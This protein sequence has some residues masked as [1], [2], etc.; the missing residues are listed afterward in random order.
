MD[1][2]SYNVTLVLCRQS[3]IWPK[4][5]ISVREKVVQ[6]WKNT[7]LPV[8]YRQFAASGAR[9]VRVRQRRCRE[10]SNRHGRIRKV[11]DWHQSQA[12]LRL[13][14]SLLRLR[15]SVGSSRNRSRYSVAVCDAIADM[16]TSERCSAVARPAAVH[17]RLAKARPVE[18]HRS[19]PDVH[20]NYTRH[21]S[22]P[23]LK[24]RSKSTLKIENCENINSK[25]VYRL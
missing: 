20:G 15:Q 10:K 21:F 19:R 1:S 9:V 16:A 5:E 6:F 14:V 13:L 2:C 12:R 4:T 23:R 25:Y 22:S 17:A 7:P 8:V 3:M 18:H 11:V 24:I